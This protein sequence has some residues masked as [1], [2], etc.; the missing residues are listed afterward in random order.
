MQRRLN[1]KPSPEPSAWSRHGFALAV[2][3]FHLFLWAYT[4]LRIQPAL[5]YERSGPLFFLSRS[6]FRECFGHPGGLLDYAVAGMAQLS[7]SSL[8]GALSFTGLAA[9]ACVT[10]ALFW[11]RV[12]GTGPGVGA[13]VP[14]YLLL[15]ARQRDDAQSLAMGLGFVLALGA[16]LSCCRLASRRAGLRIAVAALPGPLICFV[17]GVWPC[18]LYLSVV[19]LREVRER[20][21]L[22]GLAGFLLGLGASAVVVGF[23]GSPFHTM[24]NPW[25][26]RM[27]LLLA[28]AVFLFVPLSLLALGVLLRRT[29]IEAPTHSARDHPPKSHPS[30][31]GWRATGFRRAAVGAMSVAALAWVWLAFDSRDR[32]LAEI[33]FAAAH[34]DHSRVAA[35]AAR[36]GNL[37]TAAEVRLHLALF[38]TGRLLTDLFACTN[39]TTWELLPGF[40]AGADASRAQADTLF[41]LGQVN[42][43]EHLAHEV[44]EFEGNRPDLLRLLADINV[45][46]DRP[47][48]ARVFL[49]AL[50]QSPVHR[51]RAIARLRELATDPR[52][53]HDGDLSVIRSRL[54]TTDL[55]HDGMPTATFLD[56]LLHSN[57]RNQ[58]ALEYLLAHR[59]LT[60]DLERLAAKVGLLSDFGYKALPRHCAEAV[61]LHQRL[62]GVA[63]DLRG[64][65]IPPETRQQFQAMCGAIDRG[66]LRST[67]GARAFVREFGHTYWHYYFSRSAE[68]RIA[69]P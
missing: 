20:H 5:G 34:R 50:S 37:P 21:W 17:A 3:G 68:N 39:L 4:W 61:L 64:C 56:Q 24:F 32:T 9:L 2:A 1:N 12:L 63:V 65:Q 54:A 23:S 40:D 55:P 42:D 8:L 44:L 11:R 52:L 25:G 19:A 29:A 14:P 16:A 67:E 48:T 59:L 38:H 18:L 36:L 62:R 60:L 28:C 7:C 53:A 49:N 66:D 6:F 22:A 69:K 10:T 47:E 33:E 57:P 45:L 27:M 43:A 51:S 35:A 31:A 41:E 15:L 46:K 13:F 58:M 26:T 30:G